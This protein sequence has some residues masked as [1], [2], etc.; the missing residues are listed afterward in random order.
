MSEV[1]YEKYEIWSSGL[2]KT[3]ENKGKKFNAVESIELRVEPGIHGFLGPNGA[4][5]TTTINMLIGGLAITSGEAR[6][7]G[8][9]AGSVGAKQLIGFL[10]QDPEF[11]D[12]MTGED[13]LIYLGQLGGLSKSM[14]RTKSVELLKYFDI[15]G[16]RTR[17][18]GK[19][20]GGMKQKIGIA[21]A[22]IHEPK[23]LILDEPT[24]NL[25]P[26]GR[27]N[28]IDRIKELSETVSV[29][30]SS[31]IL[32]EI[33]QMCETV[34]MINHGVLVYAGSIQELKNRYI[35][36]TY[37]LNTSKNDQI[38][39]ALKHDA[40]INRTWYNPEL[41]GQIH[42]LPKDA[43][44]LQNRIPHLVIENEATLYSFKQPEVSLQD[45]FMQIMGR[46]KQGGI[47]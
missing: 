20:S 6:V 15:W 18:I 13:Y 30:V 41:P 44:N 19:Y 16:E 28:I 11:Y 39:E 35:G 1:D 31:H 37:L 32:A 43:L 45:I 8:H 36:N 14:S 5:K 42:I 4:G 17:V 2:T 33:E 22:L 3:F 26:I 40:N 21:A 47:N 29:F 9:K 34:T 7:R 12:T 46:K 10:P 27:Q 38:M 25:D 24:A 23:I